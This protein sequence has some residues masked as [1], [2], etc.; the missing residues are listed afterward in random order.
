MI[1]RNTTPEEYG[2]WFNITDILGYFTLLAGVL[3]FW[4]M[5]F[6]TRGNK[7]AAKT[8]ILANLT[9][10]VIATVIYLSITPFIVSIFNIPQQYL[11]LYFL[12]SIQIIELYLLNALQA[13]LQAKIPH[14]IGYGL[15]ITEICKIALGYVLIIRLNQPLLGAMISLIVAFTCQIIYF[16]LLLSEEL[17]EKVQWKYLKEW[18]KGSAANIYNV[19]GNQIAA[20]IFILLYIYGGGDARGYYG[21][22]AQIATV[23][24]YSSFLAFALYPKLLSERKL[25]D[26]ETTLKMVLM[27]AIP[28]TTGA[29]VLPD[30]F[31]T[32]L[33]TTYVDAV[34]VLMML[35]IDA[36]IITI[37]SF[38]S[39]VLYG[40]E[41]LD[42]KAIISFKELAR[43]KLF[44]AFSLPYFHSLVTLPT[45]F[46]VLS[47]Y[48][49]N[50]PL[51][52][53]LYVAIINSAARFLMFII[54]CTV[55][56]KI[57]KIKVPWR[58]IAKYLFAS[59]VMAAMLF[60][61]WQPHP[62][63]IITTLGVTAVGGVVYFTLLITID[64][65]VRDLAKSVWRE[66]K[67]KFE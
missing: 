21:A 16:V 49:Q 52:S 53:A 38:L 45:T 10:S 11:L 46:Y 63:R 17:K 1:A 33:Q 67:V 32:L 25:E 60:F 26:V 22:A 40:L 58:N 37:S 5:R 64:K 62:T 28:M 18:L 6:V 61:G 9:I 66:I 19:I 4:T 15:L 65:E 7:G 59:A 3:P 23:I 34:L 27:F 47:A 36:F 50:Q 55:V 24:T 48:A 56:R 8:G 42:E 54:L 41:K 20:F 35:A 43:S 57:V 29:L 39:F 51:N 2:L 44:F 30:S 12:I 14:T 31:L 13:C